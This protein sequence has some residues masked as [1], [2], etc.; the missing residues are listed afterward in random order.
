MAA[1]MHD[2]A[3]IS[4]TFQKVIRKWLKALR[5]TLYLLKSDVYKYFFY[6]RF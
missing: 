4:L 6:I 1:R 3:D 5:K 2:T